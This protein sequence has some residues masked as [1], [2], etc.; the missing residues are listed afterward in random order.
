MTRAEVGGAMPFTL[1]EMVD[2][3]LAAVSLTCRDKV[4]KVF[5]VSLQLF[6]MVVQS[7]RVERDVAAVKKLRLVIKK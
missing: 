6:N 7:S 2:G 1:S 3:T 5:N 4:I